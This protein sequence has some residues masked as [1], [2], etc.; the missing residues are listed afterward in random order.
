MPSMPASK[1]AGWS[2]LFG[3]TFMHSAQRM[4]RSRNCALLD[5]ARRA[6][7]L[8]VVVDVE[9]VGDARDGEEQRAR[10]RR[11]EARAAVG[12][13]LHDGALAVRQEAELD[14]VLGAGVLA[15]EAHV[16]L[17]LPP[18]HA[19]LRRVSALTMHQAQVAIGAFR[20]VFLHSEER[21][22]REHAQKRAERAK[23]AAPESRDEAIE[24]EDSRRTRRGS[25]TFDGSTTGAPARRC[26][27]GSPACGRRRSGARATG[28]ASPRRRGRGR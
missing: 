16:A 6:D 18:L 28:R 11:G 14:D 9:R 22:S 21:E 10:A 8:R 5:R 24:E 26:A 23:N 15:V 25:T 20:V 7:H 1:N 13:G 17:V 19:A 3:H 2:A 12:V 27:R 4:Q